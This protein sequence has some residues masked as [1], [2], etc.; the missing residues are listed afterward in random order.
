MKIQWSKKIMDSANL[1]PVPQHNRTAR[2]PDNEDST[3]TH[4]ADK[5][6]A[7]SALH[8]QS[9]HYTPAPFFEQ[10]FRYLRVPPSQ[11]HLRIARTRRRC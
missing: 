1:S 6:A 8:W 5:Q 3:Q 11:M 10:D 7:Y 2:K 9:Q 4:Y